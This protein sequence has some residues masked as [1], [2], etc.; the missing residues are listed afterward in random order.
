MAARYDQNN[1]IVTPGRAAWIR[2]FA[3]GGTTVAMLPVFI[4][5]VC[6]GMGYVRYGEPQPRLIDE[7]EMLLALVGMA[8]EQHYTSAVSSGAVDNG[9]QNGNGLVFDESGF[10]HGVLLREHN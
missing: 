1:D 3:Y 8:G 9:L 4:I 7:W 2:T 5:M 10:A 6:C